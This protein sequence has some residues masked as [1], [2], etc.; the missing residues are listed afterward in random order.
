MK[1]EIEKFGFRADVLQQDDYFVLPP[2]SNDAKR[3]EDIT[4]VGGQ[5]V[6]TEL[7]DE[8]LA[9]AQ[10]GEKFDDRAPG[11]LR[12]G[13]HYRGGDVPRGRSVGSS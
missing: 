6:R 1:E 2:K 5:E 12:R 11:H 4:W 8:H 7:L 10:R 9:A 3:R 13:P